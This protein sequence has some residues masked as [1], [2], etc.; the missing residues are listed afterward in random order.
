ME[1]VEAI[2]L[3]VLLGI[4][5]FIAVIRIAFVACDAYSGSS[6]RRMS[7]G[8]STTGTRLLPRRF[9]MK[10]TSSTPLRGVVWE[11]ATHGSVTVFP[12]VAKQAA[13]TTTP[14]GV[15]GGVR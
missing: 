2:W 12:V 15:P 1:F 13:N 11:A 8:F 7:T 9:G 5:E 10:R 3:A 14:P 4:A 6:G